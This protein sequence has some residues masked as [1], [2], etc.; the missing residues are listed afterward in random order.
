[1][2]G[3][4][5]PWFTGHYVPIESISNGQMYRTKGSLS[6]SCF[7]YGSFIT[8]NPVEAVDSHGAGA[9]S[10]LQL[11][12]AISSATQLGFIFSSL[13]NEVI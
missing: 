13:K 3:A 11:L 5:I 1:M 9:E 6:D 4:F 8:T 7:K 10:E 12:W 2:I